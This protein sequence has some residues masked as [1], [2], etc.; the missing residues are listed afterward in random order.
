MSSFTGY[1]NFGNHDF[2]FIENENKKLFQR[3]FTTKKQVVPILNFDFF[4][5]Q[6]GQE[7]IVT[8][9]PSGVDLQ[10][11]DTQF[12]DSVAIC[13][14][15]EADQYFLFFDNLEFGDEEVRPTVDPVS[16]FADEKSLGTGKRENQESSST[17]KKFNQENSKKIKNK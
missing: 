2:E 1:Q 5:E 13:E 3:L 14:N 11:K 9:K 7:E 10:K 15:N 4:D 6:P 8:L 12:I 16:E 17:T